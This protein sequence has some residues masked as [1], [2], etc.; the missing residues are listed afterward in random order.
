MPLRWATH[1]RAPRSNCGAS[2]K[3]CARTLHSTALMPAHITSARSKQDG[4]PTPLTDRADRRGT[5]GQEVPRYVNPCRSKA[6]DQGTCSLSRVVIRID[7]HKY[8]HTATIDELGRPEL[9]KPLA[10][11]HKI[12]CNW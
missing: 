11:R 2:G 6:R 3:T 12:T 5:A 10:R 1:I 8:S 7:A 4:R 9:R